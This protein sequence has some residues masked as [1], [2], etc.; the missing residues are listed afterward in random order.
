MQTSQYQKK[1][2]MV[3]AISTTLIIASG[4]LY[5]LVMRPVFEHSSVPT[6]TVQLKTDL[7]SVNIDTAINT[8]ELDDI[9]KER[10]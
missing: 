1:T 6:A 3:V 9:L 8:A 4:M 7:E 2:R 5:L 10:Q